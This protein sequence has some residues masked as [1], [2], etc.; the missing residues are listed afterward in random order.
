MRPIVNV[1]F[2]IA[3]AVILLFVFHSILENV[4]FFLVMKLFGFSIF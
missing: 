2:W 4:L 1:V 3:V